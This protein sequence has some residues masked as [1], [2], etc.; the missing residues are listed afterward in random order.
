MI[1]QEPII[2]I[3]NGWTTTSEAAKLVGYSTGRVRQLALAGRIRAVKLGRQ[4]LVHEDSLLEYRATA[5]PGPKPKKEQGLQKTI[6]R[7]VHC[8]WCGTELE[9]SVP[10]R[11]RRFCSDKCRVYYWRAVKQ[12]IEA[13]ADGALAGDS[14]L[15]KDLGFPIEMA[16]YTINPD[17][18]AT[19]CAKPRNT[20]KRH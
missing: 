3:P 2:I 19:K 15:L 17:G 12:Q 11:P 5:K 13:C 8:L 9:H 1:V 16:S 10:G 20:K 14:Q 6:R 18:A 7:Q 4:W